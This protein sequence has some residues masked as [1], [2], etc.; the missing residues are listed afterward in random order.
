[1]CMTCELYHLCSLKGRE[2]LK[3]I[4]VMLIEMYR[5]ICT[6]TYHWTQYPSLCLLL[7]GEV[8]FVLLSHFVLLVLQASNLCLAGAFDYMISF[9]KLFPTFVEHKHT[10]QF[11]RKTYQI[12][13]N[14]INYLLFSMLCISTS[15]A[16]INALFCTIPTHN[17]YNNHLTY[18]QYAAFEFIEKNS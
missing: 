10:V 6:C 16:H 15:K 18:Y 2:T 13:G 14:T 8:L 1:M 3:H 11:D 9:C 4:I 5:L 17:Y 12:F 7:K